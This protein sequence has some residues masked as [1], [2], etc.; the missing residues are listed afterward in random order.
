MLKGLSTQCE[1]G[2]CGGVGVYTE[3]LVLNLWDRKQNVYLNFFWFVSITENV[4][5]FSFLWLKKINQ[6]IPTAYPHTETW[7][8]EMAAPQHS[9]IFL[10]KEVEGLGH[11][12]Q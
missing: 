1:R 12:L 5:G 8:N 4:F 9:F 7:R 2:G 6:F 11:G 3:T 10:S